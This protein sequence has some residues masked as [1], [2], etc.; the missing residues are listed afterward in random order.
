MYS[1]RA[2]Y[3]QH[4][5]QKERTGLDENMPLY[6]ATPTSISDPFAFNTRVP[7]RTKPVRGPKRGVR[8]AECPCEEV[9]GVPTSLR[10]LK[11]SSGLKKSAVSNPSISESV[12]QDERIRMMLALEDERGEG[13]KKILDVHIK[14]WKKLFNSSDTESKLHSSRSSMSARSSIASIKNPQKVK[15]LKRKR[16]KEGIT[17]LLIKSIHAL[18]LENV[19]EDHETP[20][21]HTPTDAEED[22]HRSE[23]QRV[24][25]GRSGREKEQENDHEEEVYSAMK[26]HESSFEENTPSS[27]GLS[28]G[29]SI[30]SANYDILRDSK[31]SV[32]DELKV[33]GKFIK[34]LTRANSFPPLRR[35][36]SKVRL[37]RVDSDTLLLHEDSTSLPVKCLSLNLISSDLELVTNPRIDSVNNSDSA[38]DETKGEEECVEPVT[39]NVA[40]EEAVIGTESNIDGELQKQRSRENSEDLSLALATSTPVEDRPPFFAEV[41]GQDSAVTSTGNEATANDYHEPE[42]PPENL[43]TVPA[44]QALEKS[45]VDYYDQHT[46]ADTDNMNDD[47]SYADESEISASAYSLLQNASDTESK[48]KKETFRQV[49]KRFPSL[50]EEADNHPLQ[51]SFKETECLEKLEDPTA[52]KFTASTHSLPSLQQFQFAT[53][54]TSNGDEN[55]DR[56]L[57][58]ESKTSSSIES[59]IQSSCNDLDEVLHNNRRRR[60][61]D[62][63]RIIDTKMMEHSERYDDDGNGRVRRKKRDRAY[64]NFNPR[65]LR[66]N[67]HNRCLRRHLRGHRHQEV[68]HASPLS[69]DFPLHESMPVPLT[70]DSSSYNS[71]LESIIISDALIQSRLRRTAESMRS[72]RSFHTKGSPVDPLPPETLAKELTVDTQSSD[73]IRNNGSVIEM[74]ELKPNDT[75]PSI[76]PTDHAVHESH[77][78]CNISEVS[79]RDE[80]TNITNTANMTYNSCVS[81]PSPNHRQQDE[82]SL[83]PSYPL[84]AV[85]SMVSKVCQLPPTKAQPAASLHRRSSD[86]D[87]SITPKGN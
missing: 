15:I 46:S 87:L 59:L 50:I 2:F 65:N 38:V 34:T 70:P 19:K 23:H 39:A 61:L 77:S 16:E 3:S 71:S 42:A 10:P 78:I 17:A 6:P 13:N 1:Y 20:M 37:Q 72:K 62:L 85:P 45:V 56:K 55:M 60:M 81:R 8:A 43:N 24:S 9:E 25:E 68:M 28:N 12:I 31:L 21:T 82:A 27:D 83:S 18:P 22:S 41:Q 53:A 64:K 76:P 14:G 52:L 80:F 67:L 58:A 40:S 63:I 69:T 35:R 5:A 26:Q 11:K 51:D 48:D 30:D 79:D 7:Y 36:P 84:P 73:S 54:V 29:S 33:N 86:S 66:R 57:A 44:M 74:K 47:L 4:K 32:G 75:N 49:Q